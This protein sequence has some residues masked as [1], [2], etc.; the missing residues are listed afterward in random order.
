MLN[1]S[2]VTSLDSL[3]SEGIIDFDAAAYITGT[4]ARY[5]GN[6]NCPIY[7]IPPLAI[8]PPAQDEFKRKRPESIVKTPF[9]KKAL[10]GVLVATGAIWGI[11]KLRKTPS[12]IKSIGTKVSGFFKNLFKKKP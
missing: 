5:I 6:P 3:A 4:P 1:S 9:W 11:S 2:W 7:N 8:Q 12:F 10:L